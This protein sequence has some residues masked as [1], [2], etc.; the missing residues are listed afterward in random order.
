MASW[1]CRCQALFRKGGQTEAHLRQLGALNPKKLLLLIV[2]ELDVGP[3]PQRADNLIL[4][5][6]GRQGHRK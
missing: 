6:G 2:D 3:E 4:G 1:S 5:E